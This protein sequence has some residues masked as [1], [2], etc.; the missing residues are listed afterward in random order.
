MLQSAPRARM[1]PVQFE[2]RGAPATLVAGWRYFSEGFEPSEASART[3]SCA[4]TGFDRAPSAECLADVE[5]VFEASE[6]VAE[7]PS[8]TTRDSWFCPPAA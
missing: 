1:V 5:I 7:P 3:P 6:P 4:S 2:A 8:C